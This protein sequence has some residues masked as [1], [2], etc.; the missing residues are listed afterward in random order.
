M[1]YSSLSVFQ[2]A[3]ESVLHT[4]VG[5]QFHDT[6]ATEIEK[7]VV[8]DL[9]HNK[10]NLVKFLSANRALLPIYVLGF[11]GLLTQEARAAN[12]DNHDH[13]EEEDR[14]YGDCH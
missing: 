1:K 11:Y 3:R 4:Q 7:L 12:R 8:A 10:L 9:P 5:V 14:Q 13:D 6:V 2:S